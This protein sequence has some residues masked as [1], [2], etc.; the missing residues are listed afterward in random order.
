M[1]KIKKADMLSKGNIFEDRQLIE[2]VSKELET[3]FIPDLY[4]KSMSRVF[5]EKYYE[6]EIDED[7]EAA[8]I[9]RNK[10]I[11]MQLVNDG[12]IDLE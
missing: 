12:E 6:N 1:S 7:E 10:N 2:K 4:D 5:G 3:E 11:D 8:Q 9:E